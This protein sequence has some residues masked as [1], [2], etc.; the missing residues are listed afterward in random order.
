M[1]WMQTRVTRAISN[2]A[3]FASVA[4]SIFSLTNLMALAKQFQFM[5]LTTEIVG[6][7]S[8]YK[9][10]AANAKVVNLQ[11]GPMMPDFGLPT[12][13]D[14]KKLKKHMLHVLEK[15]TGLE[16]AQLLLQYCV[17]KHSRNRLYANAVLHRHPKQAKELVAQVEA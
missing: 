16:H 9:D 17:A 2:A 5:Q 15:Q 11:I 7:P 12:M 8:V 10:F 13:A 3:S 14:V 6:I 1:G 4:M